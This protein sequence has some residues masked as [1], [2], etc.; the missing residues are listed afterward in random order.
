MVY[1]LFEYSFL[2]YIVLEHINMSV[3]F[4]KNQVPLWMHRTSKVLLPIKIVLVAWFRMIF[5]NLVSVNMLAHSFGF[6]GLQ[7]GLCLV[8]L[9]NVLFL[10]AT[11]VSYEW[12]GGRRNTKIASWTYLIVASVTTFFKMFFTTYNILTRTRFPGVTPALTKAIDHFWML[13]IA[14]MPIWFARIHIKKEPALSFT[15]DYVKKDNENDANDGAAVTPTEGS[16]L[17]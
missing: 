10:N 1:P 6:L 2:L 7:V 13:L 5:I 11:Q 15:V 14:V 4:A 17:L 3:A 9:E 12:L 16:N 8:A